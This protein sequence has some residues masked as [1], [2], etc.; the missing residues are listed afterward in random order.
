MK[1]F[2]IG[3]IVFLII[4]A[5]FAFTATMVLAQ[6]DS[7][8][9]LILCDG[10]AARPCD[11]KALMTLI[12]KVIQFILFALAVPIAAIMFAF[13]GFKMVTSGGSAEAKTQAKNIFTNA[14]FGLV[15]AAAA[16]LIVRTILMI[17]GYQGDWIGF[18]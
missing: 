14:V 6:S 4:I 3:L 1:I 10:S 5:S 9:G 12:N 13:A 11:F 18:M 2:S 7:S 17:L 16:W 15:L 8:T